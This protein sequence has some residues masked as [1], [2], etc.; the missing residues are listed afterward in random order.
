MAG[1]IF[2]NGSQTQA[3]AYTADDNLVFN[4]LTPDQI[5]VTFNPATGLSIPTI[6][7]AGGG[8]SLDF[9]AGELADA[10]LANHLVFVTGGATLVIGGDTT[11]DA[12]AA[13]G[14][15]ADAVYGFGGDDTIA[16]GGAGA[17]IA[18]GGDGEDTFNIAAAST[19][20]YNVFGEGDDDTVD[21]SA[22]TGHL[23]IFGGLGADDLS[24]GDG[25]D[26]I[27]GNVASPSG[28][29]DDGADV[30]AAGA[31][32]D[33]V[34]GNA[35]TDDIDGGAGSDRL[36]G[37]A[38]NDTI[39]GG[40]GDGND[41]IN[42][43]K[44]N[45]DITG[46]D[47]VDS[48]RGGAGDDTV[49]GGAGVDIVLGDL[50]DDSLS[51]GAGVDTLTGGDGADTFAFADGDAALP[52]SSGALK[53]LTDTITDFTAGTDF[54]VIAGHD[55]PADGELLFQEEDTSFA[56]LAA[57]QSYAQQLLTISANTDD[58]AAIQVGADTYLFYD[59]GG[60]ATIDATIKLVGVTAADLTIDDFTA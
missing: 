27:Y 23:N 24:G 25:N 56:T 45:D 38:G 43:N 51:G 12:L 39:A 15:A 48:L 5:T 33:Y 26:H 35:G 50:G 28:T 41:T 8:Q 16:I 46:G 29:V 14:S 21:G 19:G 20:N 11:N 31:G 37:G 17:H 60:G 13:A 18:H 4:T 44:G 54:I 42:G 47:G 52:A 9:N 57:A 3:T 7:L 58:I 34:N 10:S 53:G 59:A 30:I 2:E 22:A 1:F 40:T 36:F 55:A 49:D 6:T 32:S